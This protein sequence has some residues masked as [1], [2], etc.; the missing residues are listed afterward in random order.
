VAGT[1]DKGSGYVR[2]TIDGVQYWAHRLAWFYVHGCWPPHDIDHRDTIRNHN[3]LRNLRCLTRGQ[4]LQ[5]KR[6]ANA[7]SSSGILGVSW[8]ARKRKWKVGISV[9][10]RTV[11]VGRFSNK[12]DASAAYKAKK[13]E[14]HEACTL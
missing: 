5:N 12:L 10:D 9:N 13:R 14:V 1:L 4:N 7:N 11:F 3:W 2:I 8:D 6:K